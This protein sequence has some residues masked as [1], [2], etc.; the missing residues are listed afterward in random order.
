[1]D[2]ADGPHGGVHGCPLNK[3]A[4]LSLLQQV[5]RPARVVIG[6]SQV[7]V[8]HDVVGVAQGGV[9]PVVEGGVG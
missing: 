5:G 7:W 1:M 6:V 9:A 2:T 4:V 8:L 3:A